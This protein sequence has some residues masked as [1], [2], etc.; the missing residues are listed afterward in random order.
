MTL[1][2]VQLLAVA[3]V[4]GGVISLL[5]RLMQA[6]YDAR[7]ADKEAE[8]K[9]LREEIERLWPLVRVGTAVTTEAVGAARTA[10][11]VVEQQ[12]RGQP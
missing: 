1:D 4:L 5:F 9:R 2:G 8:N 6:S 10:L 12:T 7:I 11:N 3:G